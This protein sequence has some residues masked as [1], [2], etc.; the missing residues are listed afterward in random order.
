MIVL[1]GLLRFPPKPVVKRKRRLLHKDNSVMPHQEHVRTIFVAS[2][3]DVTDERTRLREV[4]DELNNPFSHFYDIRLNL[5]GWETHAV[6]GK[7]DDVQDVI[8]RQEI[9]NCDLFIG[10]MWQRYGTP[11]GRA[12]SGTVEEYNRAKARHDQDTTSVEIMMYFN[13][14]LPNTLSEVDT[15]Q[16][17]KVQEFRSSISKNDGVLY[18]IF[19]GTDDFEKKVRN[20]LMFRLYSKTG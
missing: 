7:G 10:I 5:I 8:N 14:A 19:M 1:M 12:D 3:G 6:P 15:S 13:D 2:P 4:I 11:T 9:D 18:T 16:L 20:H 17:S